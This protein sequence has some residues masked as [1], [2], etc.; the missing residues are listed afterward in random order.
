MGGLN[1]KN[2]YGELSDTS[3]AL[4]E[5]STEAKS[6]LMV[7]SDG[8]SGDYCIDEQTRGIEVP[9]ESFE[10]KRSEVIKKWSWEQCH[11]IYRNSKHHLG[12]EIRTKL[13]FTFENT[14][15]V[16]ARR[17][18]QAS[19]ARNGCWQSHGQTRQPQANLRCISLAHRIRAT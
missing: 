15:S 9:Q 6:Q 19:V 17:L 12:S 3:P 16:H 4:V 5:T 1:M 14:N 8:P 10:A 11:V 13:S 7:H 18:Q 2:I